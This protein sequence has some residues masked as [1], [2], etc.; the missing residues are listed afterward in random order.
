M[1]GHFRGLNVKMLLYYL[2]LRMNEAE[3]LY[4]HAKLQDAA[5]KWDASLEYH[6]NV[7]VFQREPTNRMHMFQR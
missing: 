4:F 3:V 2:Q 5:R 1:P 7:F 6:G